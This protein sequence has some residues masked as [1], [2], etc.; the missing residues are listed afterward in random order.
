MRQVVLELDCRCPEA[1]RYPRGGRKIH[2]SG[3]NK[4]S[5]AA[6]PKASKTMKQPPSRGEK[7]KGRSVFVLLG[8]ISTILDISLPAA[9]RTQFRGRQVRIN[10]TSA[11]TPTLGSRPRSGPR[12]AT[13]LCL[14]RNP[15]D[16]T[17]LRSPWPSGL[18]MPQL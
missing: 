10:P 17:A 12:T 3:V 9:S 18:K 8:I 13:A 1:T 15:P 16:P 7:T 11:G 2:N 5:T 4:C 6:A 14:P